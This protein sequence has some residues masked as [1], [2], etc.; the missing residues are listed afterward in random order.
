MDVNDSTTR[1]QQHSEDGDTPSSSLGAAE[2]LAAAQR[3]TAQIQGL[4]SAAITAARETGNAQSAAALALADAQ[5]KLADISSVATFAVTAKTQIADDQGVIAAKSAHIQGA[6]EHADT[7][8]AELDRILTAAKQSAT[9]AE[10]S[11]ERAAHSARA[12]AEPLEQ[13]R[14]SRATANSELEAIVSAR[15]AAKEAM[16]AAK[17][18]ADKAATVEERVSKYEARLAELE[19]E[20]NER[21]QTINKLLPGATSAGLAHAFDKRRQTFLAPGERWQKFFIGSIV[22]LVILAVTGLWYSA[23]STTYEEL[24]RLWL[25]RLPIAA[26]LVWLA[27]HSSREAALAKRLEEDYGYKSAIADSFQGFHRQMKEIG[28]VTPLNTPLAKLCEDTLATLASP[29]GRIYDKHQLTVTPGS[30]IAAAAKEL[31]GEKAPSK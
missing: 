24:G 30:E 21:L 20:C 31:A 14:A 11:V 16:A 17:V 10:S 28:A 6:Q 26:A 3:D 27:L 29:P 1:D 7:V 15:D 5:A 22:F 23:A 13:I 8:R 25:A 2:L 4:A 9:E 18:L 12:A 19:S